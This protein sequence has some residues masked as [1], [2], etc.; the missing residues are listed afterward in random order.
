MSCGL[1]LKFSLCKTC[2]L[3]QWTDVFTKTPVWTI[4]LLLSNLGFKPYTNTL[5]GL[6]L[7]YSISKYLI[8]HTET[9]T[10]RVALCA[11][12][13]FHV[14]LNI[15]FYIHIVS[16]KCISYCFSAHISWC[17]VITDLNRLDEKFSKALKDTIV[18]LSE[19][20][21][22]IYGFTLINYPPQKRKYCHTLLT[23]TFFQHH[24]FYTK[25]AVRKND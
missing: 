5:L 21:G 14:K 23:F 8:M 2:N 3:H 19:P 1:Y 10:W 15:K 25:G 6:F 24:I 4:S 18:L 17:F 22:V 9:S 12:L 16:N 7:Q 11:T 13:N 20:W